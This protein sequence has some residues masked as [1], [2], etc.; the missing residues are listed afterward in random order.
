MRHCLVAGVAGLALVAAASSG[1]G[2]DSGSGPGLGAASGSGSAASPDGSGA[3]AGTTG[4]GAA[5]LDPSALSGSAVR[6][7]ELPRT[8]GSLPYEALGG[9]L[10]LAGLVE[11]IRRRLTATR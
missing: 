4:V 2:N 6:R 9:A 3:S 8:G 11:L 7:R 5:A 1:G 10:G